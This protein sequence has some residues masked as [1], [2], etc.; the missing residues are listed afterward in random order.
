MNQPHITFFIGKPGSGKGTQAELLSL[1]TGWPTFG[2]S[3]GLR[4]IVAAG[5]AAGHKLQATM[6]AGVLTP[7]WVASHVFLKKLFSITDTGSIIFDGTS[8]TLPEAQ[9]VFDA[10]KWLDRPYHIFELKI[11]D[12]TVRGRIELRKQTS[13]RKDDEAL[14]TRL[15]E[16]YA[17]T[18]PGISYLR[19]Q[20][21]LTELD[22]E[23]TP[24]E[25]A[26]DVRKVLNLG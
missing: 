23:K 1:A 17:N 22:G 10:L 21:A 3:A 2:T 16:Y 15:Q 19:E 26:A 6:D 5:T 13:G 18:E 4:E 9:I 20:G 14:D 7:Y 25:I 12:E 11:S 24:D 8:R